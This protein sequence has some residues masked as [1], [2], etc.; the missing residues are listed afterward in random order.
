[1]PFGPH[2]IHNA[3]K[4]TFKDRWEGAEY[5]ISPGGDG[6]A[7]IEA[8]WC[9]FGNGTITN[10]PFNKDRDA[11]VARL[12]QRYGAYDDPILWEQNRPECEVFGPDG[13]RVW[14][15]I[16]DPLGDHVQPVSTT[17]EEKAQLM[18]YIRKLQDDQQ[19]MQDRL[20]ELTGGVSSMSVE[21]DSPANAP[22]GRTRSA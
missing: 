16:E 11:E 13:E 9:W 1:M 10:G 18:A 3:S 5:V 21:E 8:V 6:L 15:V 2:K 17:A 7:P 20:E 22:R 14:T 12:R 19:A 4:R